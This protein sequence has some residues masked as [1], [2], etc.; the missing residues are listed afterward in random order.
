MPLSSLVGWKKHGSGA[1]GIVL[2]V[3]CGGN[4][5]SEKIG[6]E[7]VDSEGGISGVSRPKEWGPGQPL[8]DRLSPLDHNLG[9]FVLLEESEDCLRD[10]VGGFGRGRAGPDAHPDHRRAEAAILLLAGRT[11]CVK[12]SRVNR[13]ILDTVRFDYIADLGTDSTPNGIE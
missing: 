13:R 12:A 4:W 8:H 2:L 11:V 7:V 5:N 3:A 9:D 10:I 1:L 6:E